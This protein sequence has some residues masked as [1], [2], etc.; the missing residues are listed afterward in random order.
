VQAEL[1][2]HIAE[3]PDERRWVPAGSVV[4][5]GSGPLSVQHI[6]H[7]VAVDGMYDSSVE[8]VRDTICKA[9]AMAGE[10]GANVVTVPALATGYGWLTMRSFAHAVR[11]VRDGECPQGESPVDV[12]TVVLR[13]EDDARTVR[14]ILNA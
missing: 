6:L 10:L 1:N 9:L 12:L 4:R 2:A 8:L 13:R 14:D 5:T 7:A 3:Q 11:A